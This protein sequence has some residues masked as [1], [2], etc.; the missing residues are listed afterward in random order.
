MSFGDD[1]TEPNDSAHGGQLRGCPQLLT[2]PERAL[3]AQNS[4]SLDELIS[5]AFLA[6][7]LAARLEGC[8]ERLTHQRDAVSEKPTSELAHG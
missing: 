2:P 1:V 6:R 7:R 5:I 3:L 4:W 8:I